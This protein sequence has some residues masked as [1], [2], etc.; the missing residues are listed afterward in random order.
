MFR[1]GLGIGMI[2]ILT[3]WGQQSHML[4][5]GLDFWKNF[6][7]IIQLPILLENC[8][9]PFDFTMMS[10]KSAHVGVL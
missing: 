6:N 7:T 9:N 8:I 3:L 5:R 2:T 4:S 1:L 10:V